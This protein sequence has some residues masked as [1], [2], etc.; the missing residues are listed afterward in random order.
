MARARRSSSQ[1][2]FQQSEANRHFRWTCRWIE[3]A[4]GKRLAEATN[5][6]DGTPAQDAAEFA[7][8][9]A[10]AAWLA[11][12]CKCE[13]CRLHWDRWEKKTFDAG[14]STGDTGDAKP[15]SEKGT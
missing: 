10:M 3:S 13:I 2:R 9:Q 5:A 8:S 7:E 1:R 12:K 15:N 6:A 14:P 4:E 11:K